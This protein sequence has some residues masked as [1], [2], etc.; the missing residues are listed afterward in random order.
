LMRLVEYVAFSAPSHRTKTVLLPQQTLALIEPDGQAALRAHRYSA[1]RLL[2]R[3]QQSFPGF[4][5]YAHDSTQGLAR[6]VKTTGLPAWLTVWD[7][8]ADVFFSTGKLANRRNAKA[9][10]DALQASVRHEL[11]GAYEKTQAVVEYFQRKSS[12][13]YHRLM[14]ER[15]DDAW[16]AAE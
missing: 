16:E 15:F 1:E 2:E 6:A 3:M 14:A 8:P 5:Y 4:E 11:D 10:T 7:D 9:V 13:K 12:N